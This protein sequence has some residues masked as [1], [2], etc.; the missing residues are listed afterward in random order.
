VSGSDPYN[1]Q[2]FLDA[3][4]R[5][6][7]RALSDLLA[8]SKQSHWM[9]FIFPQLAGLG[10]SP[11][12]KLYGIGSIAEAEAYLRQPTLAG[13]L[14]QC[15]DALRL[16]ASKRTAEQIFGAVDA[17]KLR[18]SLTLF[19]LVEP[20]SIFNEALLNFFGGERD[21]RTLALLDGGR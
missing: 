11:T 12:A 2:R 8:G 17:M 1:L 5:T 10:R 18:S 21:E 15:I 20:H 13:R 14:H 6:I 19:D 3:Q 16:W 4:S 7:D 9:W